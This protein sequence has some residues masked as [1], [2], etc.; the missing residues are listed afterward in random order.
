MAS[1]DKKDLDTRLTTAYDNACIT[2][3]QKYPTLPHPFITTTYRSPSEQ[4]QLYAQ[5]R[6]LPGKIITN[7]KAGQ[8]AHNS[9]PSKAF[10][11]AFINLQK[12]LDWSEDL[13]HKF[14]DIIKEDQHIEWGGDFHSFKDTPHF[15]L[16][17][18]NK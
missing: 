15:Q 10:D 7:S 1:R 9:L 3:K 6:T 16:L 13:F 18:W 5:G 14:A 11:I 2:F 4:D 8:S 17:N 12:E